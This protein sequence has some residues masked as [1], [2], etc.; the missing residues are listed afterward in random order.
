MGPLKL[1]ELAAKTLGALLATVLL[2]RPWRKKTLPVSLKSAR[3]ILLVR[4]DNR[5][6][7]ALLMTPAIS[8]L[9]QSAKGFTVD[10]LVH[11]RVARVLEGHVEVDRLLSFDSRQAWM[12]PLAPGVQAI[13]SR[14]YDAVV[15]C[16]NWTAPSVSGA[17]LTR[18]MGRDSLVIG[19]TTFPV[20]GLSD[21]AVAPLPGVESEVSQRVHLLSPL[22]PGPPVEKLS[23]RSPRRKL[24]FVEGKRF[25]VVNP[26]GRL[27][28]RRIP[29]GTFAAA[30]RELERL[31][32]HAVITWGPGEDTLASQVAAAAPGAELAPPTDLDQLADLM[33]KAVLTV[34]NN[35][36]PMH[37]SV[38]VGTPTLALF[39]RMNMNRWGHQRAPHQMLDL[40][41]AA[42][43]SAPLEPVITQAVRQFATGLNPP[44]R[45]HF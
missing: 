44:L 1:L 9:K 24:A 12:G 33:G 16:T 34:C 5:V 42:S 30:A 3:R 29:P 7:E 32:I 8:T 22:E 2:W 28:W 23:F 36:G 10:V 13:R 21:V 6:G 4:L 17:I 26:G 39:L 27:G 38:A 41:E 37:L 25:A 43:R 35:T 20:G 45:A 31:G 40:T 19:P 14:L 18:L 15:H 11:P